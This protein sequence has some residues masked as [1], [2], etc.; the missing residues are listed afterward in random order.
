MILGCNPFRIISR[1]ERKL[2][3]AALRNSSQII[4][5]NQKRRSWKLRSATCPANLPWTADVRERD[6]NVAALRRTLRVRR[7]TEVVKTAVSWVIQEVSMT[8][9]RTI[10]LE[11]LVRRNFSEARASATF[12]LLRSSLGISTVLQT[13]GSG[14]HPDIPGPSVHRQKTGPQ[15]RQSAPGR[16][17]VLLRQ[18]SAPTLE[19][20]GD[21]LPKRVKHLPKC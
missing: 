9:L 2:S 10:M 20:S 12:E 17:A 15:H 19:H 5:A 21:S 18:D 3:C 16:F 1:Y 14:A 4:Q 8:H 13:T 11:E 6:L 7:S